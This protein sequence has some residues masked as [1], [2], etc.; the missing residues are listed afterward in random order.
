RADRR[1]DEP[2][3]RHLEGGGQVQGGGDR[4][5]AEPA[6]GHGAAS[7]L[8]RLHVADG[9]PHAHP[10]VAL[11]PETRRALIAGLGLIGGSIG[12]A[13]RAHGWHVAY[14]D[15][16]VDDPRGAADERVTE[17]VSAD[18]VVLATPVDVAVVEVAERR[19]RGAGVVTSVCSVMSPLRAVA[20]DNFVAGHPLAGSEQRG[21][22]AA[23]G[24]LFRDKAWFVDRD[25]PLVAEL[26]A[27]CGARLERVDADDHDRAV[28]LT[29]HL[30][31]L[32]STA[33]AAHLQDSGVDQR[34]VGSGLRTFLRLAESDASVW[35]PV[36]KA[37]EA[38]IAPHLDAVLRIAHEM[39]RGAAG[40]FA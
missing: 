11:M 19:G 1:E 29:S 34:F 28:A 38:H 24:D 2:E 12:I 5:E 4:R 40:P 32:L 16:F 17:I 30:P 39:L 35:M 7:V 23:R 33:L 3:D 8:R 20:G 18:V 21:L 26:V 13:L 37:N 10:D 22:A 9:R 6:A 25:E 27:A 31:Q 36:L 15:P 14:L